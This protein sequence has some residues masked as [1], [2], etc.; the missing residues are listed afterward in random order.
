VPDFAEN[1]Q[2]EQ[3][4]NETGGDE[5]NLLEVN[6]VAEGGETEEAWNPPYY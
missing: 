2:G 1:Q 4:P 6:L 5:Q 3:Y